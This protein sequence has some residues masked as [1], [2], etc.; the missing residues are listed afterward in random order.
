MKKF[1]LPQ[2]LIHFLMGAVI[3]CCIELAWRGRTHFTMGILGGI[4]FVILNDIE[5]ALSDA[6]LL[7]KSVLGAGIITILELPAGVLFNL[8]MN[9]AIW[10]YTGL[11][12]NI[13]GQICPLYTFLWFLLCVAA[14]LILKLWRNY[15]PSSDSA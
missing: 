13:L 15:K 11:S 9:L 12:H 2:K 5:S 10:D 14:F 3:Y 1:S 8:K 7:F 4:V 6:P